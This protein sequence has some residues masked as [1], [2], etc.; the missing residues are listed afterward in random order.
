LCTY[1][2]APCARILA[3]C[4]CI[5]PLNIIIL[6]DELNGNEKYKAQLDK[7][8]ITAHKTIIKGIRET[9]ETVSGF[10]K[11]LSQR[12]ATEKWEPAKRLPTAAEIAASVAKDRENKEKRLKKARETDKKEEKIRKEAVFRSHAAAALKI[13]A[14][15]EQDKIL[16]DIR[17]TRS[18]ITIDNEDEK[19]TIDDLSFPIDDLP[20]VD[21]PPF[22]IDDLPLVDDL[23]PPST[24][25]ALSII[26][27]LL[28]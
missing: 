18:V 12:S 3:P 20:P 5:T 26:E 4:A 6:R 13:E 9:R 17:I 19:D 7:K 21:D 8:V 22:P 15:K 24:A 25:P 11:R 14:A 27:R 10:A 23:P 1:P 2:G 16:K 28:D